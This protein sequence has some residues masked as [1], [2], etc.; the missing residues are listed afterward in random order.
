MLA[1]EISEAQPS[2]FRPYIIDFFREKGAAII[3]M[4]CGLW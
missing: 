4:F 3:A 1:L 2:P